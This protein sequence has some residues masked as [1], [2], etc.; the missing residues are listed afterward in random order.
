[1][2]RRFGAMWSFDCTRRIRTRAE[3]FLHS[4]QIPI[5]SFFLFF[6]IYCKLQSTQYRQSN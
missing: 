4:L 6:I 3:S 2:S 1:M 5:F